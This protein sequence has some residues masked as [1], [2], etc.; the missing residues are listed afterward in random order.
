LKIKISLKRLTKYFYISLKETNFNFQTTMPN[1]LVYYAHPGQQHSKVNIK[2]AKAASKVSG[3]SF[4][5][6]YAEYPRFQININKEQQRLI[7]HDVILFQ[8]PLFWY[9]TPSLIKEWIDLVLEQGFAYG[10]GDTKLDGK[11]MMLATTAAGCPEAYSPN[12]LQ[13]Y[14][15]R[16]FLT[17]LEQTA[18]LSNMHFSPP[19][20]LFDALHAPNNGQ[21]IQHTQGYEDILQAIRDDRYDFDAAAQH[22][23]VTSS[24]LNTLITLK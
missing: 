10:D 8:F 1:L 21:A 12:G 18:S 9:S 22:E 2:M 19:Y 7:E 11:T 16:T 15:L 4:V 6:L 24:N 3:I 13:N 14:S 17:P 20:I 23:Y 5:D